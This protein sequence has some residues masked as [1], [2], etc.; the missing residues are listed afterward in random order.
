VAKHTNTRAKI[1]P[2]LIGNS[3]ND[4]FIFTAASD[5]EYSA[6]Y[7]SN[8]TDAR[9]N[10][11]TLDFVVQQLTNIMLTILCRH[12]F[13]AS[14]TNN[15]GFCIW[16]LDL[17]AFFTITANYSSSHTELLL[18]DVCLTNLPEDPL[19]AVWISDWSLITRIQIKVKVK[20]MLRLRVS[21]PVCLGIKHPSGA[22][23]QIFISAR[24]LQVCLYGAFS[25]TRGRICP[26]EPC[27]VMAGSRTLSK[28]RHPASYS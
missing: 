22:Y 24:Q 21:R 28:R 10:Y 16:W 20:V 14:V 1:Y 18:N 9:P 15:N 23:D 12:V 5:V 25:L 2:W 13:G 6:A 7:V 27:C 8:L 26:I 19:I 11:H 17:L 4:V 3:N